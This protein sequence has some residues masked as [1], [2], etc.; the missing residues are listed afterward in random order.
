MPEATRP[1][2]VRRVLSRVSV[3]REAE[4][5]L[6]YRYIKSIFE[7]YRGRRLTSTAV[8]R[9]PISWSRRR[10]QALG[11]VDEHAKRVY[12]LRGTIRC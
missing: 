4:E 1:R 2:T 5:A 7:K 10:Q 9:R 11:R 8:A 12:G 3:M 6:G